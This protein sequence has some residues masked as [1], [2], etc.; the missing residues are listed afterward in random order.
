M[1]KTLLLMRHAKSD[2]ADDSLADIERPLNKRGKKNAPQMGKLLKKMDSVPSIIISSIAKRAN[3]T[4]QYVAKGCG[5][6]KDIEYFSELYTADQEAVLEK[7]EAVNGL[8]D[9]VLLVGHNPFMEDFASSLL[10]NGKSNICMPTAAILAIS[11]ENNSW[12][13]LKNDYKELLWFITP[14]ML[15]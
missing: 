5:Y 11:I 4:A 14:K 3:Q 9:T 10:S 13:N 12:Q 2:W 7:L 8:Y 1:T 15:K 6:V